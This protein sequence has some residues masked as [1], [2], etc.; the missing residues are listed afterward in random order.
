MSNSTLSRKDVEAAGLDDWRP[1]VS[2]LYTRFRTGNFATGLK[3]VNLIGA[4]A[5]EANHHPDL[6]LRYPHLNITLSS[7]DAGGITQR[8]LDL[9]KKISEHA[10]SLDVKADPAAA[11]TMLLA[12]DTPDFQKVKPFWRAV[13]GYKDHKGLD[14]EVTDDGGAAP[15]LWFQASGSDEPRQRFHI[16]IVVPKEV[17]QQRID[18]AVAAGGKVVDTADTF[19]VLADADGNK[20]CVCV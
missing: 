20:V 19:T 18:A 3:L 6:D 15:P 5:E 16:D 10:A 9:A 2:A 12:L 8:D 1:L 14:D 4:S 13:L 11:T 7:H 17:A